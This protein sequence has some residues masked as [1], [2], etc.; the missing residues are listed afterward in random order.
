MSDLKIKNFAAICVGGLLS[1]ASVAGPATPRETPD[2]ALLEV[3]RSAVGTMYVIPHTDSADG[4]IN[5]CG[6]EFAALQRYNSSAPES[7]VKLVGSFYLRSAPQTGLGYMLKMG[8]FDPLG[9]PS[10]PATR[11][12]N[13]FIRAPNGKAPKNSVRLDGESGFA[14]YAGLFDAD[15]IN[16]YRAIVQSRKLEVGFNREAGGRDVTSILDL[17]V[18]STQWVDGK[19]KRKHSD[20]A[21]DQFVECSSTLLDEVE[22]N[23]N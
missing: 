5:A 6:L 23:L 7:Y 13:A 3:L 14:L 4:V 2:V 8:L 18:E 10:L 15:V 11:P 19:A 20:A 9:G 16:A 1:F 21:V 22:A 12:A 17:T